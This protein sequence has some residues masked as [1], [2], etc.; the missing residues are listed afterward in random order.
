MSVNSDQVDIFE[1]IEEV[2][3]DEEITD[4]ELDVKIEKSDE[5]GNIKTEVF[6]ENNYSEPFQIIGKK[7]KN[8]ER[9][10]L[11]NESKKIKE[12]FVVFEE[13][14]DQQ[15]TLVKQ[16][17]QEIKE[18]YLDDLNNQVIKIGQPLF[19]RVLVLLQIYKKSM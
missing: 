10:N 3:C 8:Q 5:Q 14:D 17:P 7:R 9:S 11:E 15:E 19:N 13:F 4:L 16:E 18:I 6:E 12:E 2:K 1:K